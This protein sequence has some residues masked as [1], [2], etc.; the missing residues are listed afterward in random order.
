MENV[1]KVTVIIT[2]Y[3]E[4]IDWLHFVLKFVDRVIIYNKGEDNDF[5]LTPIVNDKIEVINL[6]NV[7][8]IDHTI[9]YHIVNNWE[10]LD[11]TLISLPGSILICQHKEH[12]LESIIRRIKSI[13]KYK[14]FYG[15][16]F[17][18][19]SKNFNYNIDNYKAEGRIN[20]NDN[21]FIKSEYKD[22]Q[23]WKNALIDT[24]PMHFVSMRG[25]FMVSKENIKYIS[26]DIYI[27]LLNSLSVGDNIEN[28]HFAERIWAHLFKQISDPNK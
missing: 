4:K 18:I 14:G 24:L 3:K 6:P 11:D 1:K 15:P 26:K 23:E 28:G 13:N 9:A 2:R 21:P 19:V 25:M 8:R 16:R 12:Y 10:N 5:F 22:F 27:N 7:G 20:T 17:H